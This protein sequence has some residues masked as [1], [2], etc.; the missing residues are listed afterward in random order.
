MKGKQQQD[1]RVEKYIRYGIRK[2]SFGA[3]SV[4]IA[5][6]LMFL[7]NGAV[8][9]SETA[10]NGNVPGVAVVSP[11][12]EENGATA[13]VETAKEV[14]AEETKPEVATPKVEESK[15]E[16]A[17][18]S[19]EAVTKEE[20]APKLDKSQLE[21]YVNEVAGKLAAG[22]YA[23]KTDESLTLLN[24]DLEAAKAALSSATSQD[25]LKAAYNKLVTTVNSKLKNKPVEKKETPAVDTTNGKETVGKKAENTEKK[26]DSNAIE[27]TGSKDERNGKEIEKGSNLRSANEGYTYSSTELRKKNGEF[28][29]ATGKS[30]YELDSN[31][32]YRIYVHGYQ[33]ENTEQPEAVNSVAG[34]NGRTDIPLSREEAQKLGEEAEL[35]KG[36]LRPTGS[37]IVGT[38]DQNAQYGSNGAYEF[39]A[40]EIYGYTYEQGNHYIYV[41]DVKKRFS[42]SDAATAAGYKITN[43]ELT[44]LIPGA[45][46]NEKADTIEGYV[47]SS[48]QNGV[49]DMR[50]KVTVS[51]P[52][53][54]TQVMDFQNLRSGWMGW[55]DTTAPLI[56][57]SS[58]LVTIGDEVSHDIKYVDN[59]AMTRDDATNYTVNGERVI[60]GAKT[61]NKGIYNA[62]FTAKD[63]STL[64][65]MNGPRPV[66]AHTTVNGTYAKN[67]EKTTINDVIPG[68][69][70][71]PQ[72]G[73]F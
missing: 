21:S 25:E 48:I 60:A 27:N 2:Y 15:K 16:D 69:D 36:K 11:N 31:A 4:A 63:G 66:T 35:W 70:Y 6:G 44:N 28:A 7:G 26:S 5:A 42:L 65:T 52:D 41:T 3:A 59:D 72:T 13:K 57:G 32:D 47:S 73:L 38:L 12:A 49:Y 30:Y 43:I 51:K 55:Q 67:G 33:S 53:G 64:T 54:T 45:A 19:A 18:K 1:F 17:P 68:L 22:K 40:T 24:A 58:K 20:V 37:T 23:N 39:L 9:A 46:Y 8:S 56:Q 29:T 71:T 62:T 61:V 14:K 50:Y 10:V 34:K